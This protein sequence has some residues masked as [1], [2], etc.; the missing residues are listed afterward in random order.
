M[1][2][3]TTPK[4]AIAILLATTFVFFFSIVSIH[5]L[6]R[7]NFAQTPSDWVLV[8]L[9]ATSVAICAV[10]WIVGFIGLIRILLGG[11]ALVFFFAVSTETFAAAPKKVFHGIIWIAVAIALCLP[12]YYLVTLGKL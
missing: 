2:S 1:F 7:A 8:I 4:R 5:L 6:T 10:G 3:G 12:F 9:A 11:F